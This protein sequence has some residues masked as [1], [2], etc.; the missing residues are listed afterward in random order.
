[1]KEVHN[2]AVKWLDKFSDQEI[3]YIETNETHKQ[4]VEAISNK[5]VKLA[6][7]LMTQHLSK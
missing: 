7:E 6:K 2:F 4:I 1:M 3:D 5:D